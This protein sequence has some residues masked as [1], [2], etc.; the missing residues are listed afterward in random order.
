[1]AGSIVNLSNI[2]EAIEQ[3]AQT[4]A[5]IVDICNAV[6]DVPLAGAD[7]D[8]TKSNAKL[9]KDL[10]VNGF[11]PVIEAINELSSLEVD[12]K[13]MGQL[14]KVIDGVN[15]NTGVVANSLKNSTGTFAQLNTVVAEVN[16]VLNE[17]STPM[18]ETVEKVKNISSLISDINKTISSLTD[19]VDPE[20]NQ[21]AKTAMNPIK[22]FF[23]KQR[24]KRTFKAIRIFIAMI[25]A[26][27]EELNSVVGDLDIKT[28]EG[29]M[30][31]ISSFL[32]K[33]N[34]MITNISLFVDPK[35]NKLAVSPVKLFF[36]KRQIRKVFK[37]FAELI[38]VLIQEAERLNKQLANVDVDKLDVLEKI[39][40]MVS[41]IKTIMKDVMK[42]SLLV[43]PFT[44]ASIIVILGMIIFEGVIF[45][46]ITVLQ[47]LAKL[48]IDPLLDSITKC[49]VLLSDIISLFKSLIKLSLYLI[50]AGPIIILGFIAGI[51]VMV[52]LLLFVVELN[53]MIS[54]LS[55]IPDKD[56]TNA[57]KTILS[58]VGLFLVLIG[59]IIIIIL[60]STVMLEVVKASVIVLLGVIA[61]MIVVAAVVY[62][63]Q[64]ISKIA[65]TLKVKD[66]LMVIGVFVVIIVL[67]VLFL[68]IAA[69][70]TVLQELANQIE[71]GTIIVFVLG[72]L[73]FAVVMGLLGLGCA[74]IAS[75]LL[76]A[77]AAIIL[78]FVAIA[79]IIAI[80]L[81][82]VVMLAL[83]EKID[84]DSDKIQENVT[85][86]MSTVQMI[87]DSL[88]GPKDET[89]EEASDK[90][91]IETLLGYL[92]SGIAMI[93]KAIM[94]VAYLALMMVA[95][96]LVLFIAA[97]LRL[98]QELELDT[99]K[100]ETN[101]GVVMDT[102]QLVVD[103]IFGPK[104]DSKDDPSQKSFFES[105]L[106]FMGTG[107]V[108]ILQA[109]LAIAYLALMVVAILLV[110]FIASE[111][112]LLQEIDLNQSLISTNIGIVMD[113]A[114][115]V[116]DA[117][118][119]P[120]DE[121]K[122][123]SSDKGF[124]YTLLDFL[125]PALAKIVGAIMSIA[126][127]ALM[128]VAILLV[129][130]IATE[131]RILQE[132]DLNPD[133][134]NVNVKIVMDTAQSVINYVFDPEDDKANKPSSKGFFMTILDFFC[135]AL[136][137]IFGAIMSIAY[138]ALMVVAMLL[139]NFIAAELRVLQIIDLN[140]E[141]ISANVEIVMNT[142][143]MVVDAIFNPSDDKED[144]PSSKGFFLT[145]LDFFCPAYAK[146]FGA[147]MSIAYL[148]L[149]MVAVVLIISIAKELE[150]LQQ[151]DLD[152]ELI[153]SNVQTVIDTANMVTGSLFDPNDDKEDKPSS[154]GFF[155]S[156]LEFFCPSL[157]AIFEAIMAIAYLA[158][159]IVAVQLIV[160][161][162]K[163]L[164]FIAGVQLDEETIKSNVQ[165][166]I[167]S[168]QCVIDAVFQRD[169]T[170][171]EGGQG[172]FRK[173][174]KMILPSRLLEF[175]D[176]I[177]AIGYLSLVKTCVGLV[178]E[179]AQN[180]TAIAKLPSM[181]GIEGK[182][183][184]V[185]NTART[186]INAVLY[187]GKPGKKEMK[188]LSK[189]TEEAEDYLRRI[190]IIPNKLGEIVK[191]F[192]ELKEFGQETEDKAVGVITTLVKIVSQFDQLSSSSLDKATKS[193]FIITS[194]TCL[195][196][197][198]DKINIDDEKV[199]D[200]KNLMLSLIENG[201]KIS[202]INIDEKHI[203]DLRSGF[204]LVTNFAAYI[205]KNCDDIEDSLDAAEDMFDI[206]GDFLTVVGKVNINESKSN[207]IKDVFKSI[208]EFHTEIS[209]NAQNTAGV[210]KN[211]DNF[212][213]KINKLEVKKLQTATKLFE[214]MARFSESINGNFDSMADTLNE[215]IAPLMEELKDLL[216]D[217]QEKV[218]Q[219]AEQPAT[220]MDAEKRNIFN[221]MQ[222]NGQT[223]NLSQTEVAEK[224]DNKYQAELQQRYGIDE[225]AS[226][227]SQLIDL[228]QNGDAR[229][230]TT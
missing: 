94:A 151:I 197:Q 104:D 179:M 192:E 48:E 153:T 176:A 108:K 52:G 130:F 37:A 208:S 224:V 210:L 35:K 92:G 120:D 220:E 97:Q 66:I 50:I 129:N 211:Y 86:V 118:F 40:Q 32:K 145:I 61:M 207:S 227:L 31:N 144:K 51:L 132:I 26:E 54:I 165:K 199:Q 72:L 214:E 82:T 141:K 230:R 160:E 77:V 107:F 212:L 225:V 190:Q 161:I 63:F 178:G 11:K 110:L 215:K 170:K 17:S 191:S 20:K 154:K 122:V 69:L 143:Q 99:K 117:V 121:S 216:N 127:L 105:I 142:A 57:K 47:L 46:I 209:K 62:S 217:V 10:C 116:I 44:L 49:R 24:I 83:L 1:M 38:N 29:S 223:T 115:S 193:N 58:V 218:A 222:E 5:T 139:V 71:V 3:N 64:M 131:L 221:R 202:Q 73:A 74:A 166:V 39:S 79:T 134:I 200:I 113:T 18:S 7:I 125:C 119:E 90:G 183:Q 226:K 41:A 55:K 21:I 16:T 172:I 6:N 201:D 12:P 93:L 137:K 13:N 229:V 2:V 33:I 136:S 59:L 148:A 15:Q 187:G 42:M 34:E 88:F 205:I 228:F 81:V 206:Y 22:L 102:A 98:L 156:I 194:I 159:V 213:T 198:I 219:K 135:P 128:V 168:A 4:L 109:I 188:K 169:N 185:T 173:L 70:L 133:K 204:D 152:A 45:A 167:R 96:L 78:V 75:Y 9:L 19:L 195:I 186:V 103:S 155:L 43:I 87:I 181:N 27:M 196:R 163:Q 89:E 147:I 158:L 112:R 80:M 124:F 146:I 171:P 65:S 8:K 23:A 67:V 150:Y 203:G 182:V 56:L 184:T 101:V 164:Q 36:A 14:G 25:L 111:L 76:P 91:F 53:I 174:L 68:V 84:L 126:Y 177:M 30:N 149:I 100:I 162:A 157:A 180:L 60:L 140:P 95:I 175:L 106:E 138:L 123:N 189:A 114:Q 28:L 85:K